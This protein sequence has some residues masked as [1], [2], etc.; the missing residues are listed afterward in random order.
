MLLVR[1]AAGVEANHKLWHS[2]RCMHSMTLL[3]PTPARLKLL[4]AC[5]QCHS[6]RVFTLLSPVGNVHSVQSLEDFALGNE[7]KYDADHELCHTP[8]NGLKDFALLLNGNC[9]F[10]CPASHARSSGTMDSAANRRLLP[11]GWVGIVCLR[12][13]AST[14]RA[15]RSLFKFHPFTINCVSTVEGLPRAVLSTQLSP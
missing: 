7:T 8:L 15:W 14:H 3:V 6:S 5:D 2:T 11:C 1:T 10:A 13:P 9:V 4:H 12:T